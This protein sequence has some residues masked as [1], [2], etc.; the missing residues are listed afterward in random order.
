[1][2]GWAIPTGTPTPAGTATPTETPTPT[3]TP[4]PSAA[5]H[6]VATVVP[7]TCRLGQHLLISVR[8]SGPAP[9]EGELTL[10]VQS[11]QGEQIFLGSL[12][13]TIKPGQALTID[14]TYVV[15]QP[16]LVLID[17]KQ[18]LGDG[19]VQDHRVD[20]VPAA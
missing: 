15:Q 18:T 20:C 7:G 5:F 12:K 16:A 6:L 2:T 14:S 17:P 1:P 13:A 9:F 8:N 3:A 4:T 11:Q 19:N 10:S